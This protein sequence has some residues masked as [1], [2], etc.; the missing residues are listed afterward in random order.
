[1][2]L[3]SWIQNLIGHH[4][5]DTSDK[6]SEAVH[7]TEEVVGKTR[8]LRRTIEPYARMND[9]FIAMWAD[10]YEAAQEHHIYKGPLR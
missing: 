6:F 2:T 3:M 9:P 10:R 7:A 5:I 1:M 4:H 8:E